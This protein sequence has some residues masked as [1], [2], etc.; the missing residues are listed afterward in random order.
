MR[1]V[2]AFL[3]LM[4]LSTLGYANASSEWPLYDDY[5]ARFVDANGRVADVTFGGK[6]TS[7]G[8]S[9]GLFF[10]LVANQ[11]QHFDAILKW[12]SDNL[13]EGQLGDKL[14]AWLWNKKKDGSWGVIDRNSASDSDLWIAY[15]LLQAERLWKEP[16]YGVMGRKLLRTIERKETVHAD[17]AGW[18]FMPAPQ[19]FKLSNNRYRIVSSYMPGFI[20]EYL[21]EVD[22]YGP[23]QSIWTNF[24]RMGPRIFTAG[25]AP[26]RFVVTSDDVVLPDT[27]QKPSASYDSIRVYLWAGMSGKTGKE[28]VKLL[29][30]YAKLIRQ[31][32]SP[33]ENVDPL[34][35][36]A[37]KTDYSPMGFTGAV[38]PYLHMV[39]DKSSLQKQVDRLQSIQNKSPHYYDQSLIMFGKGWLDGYYRFDEGGRLH[40]KWMK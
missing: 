38:L 37:T 21:A 25:I 4:M 23:W 13:A 31:Y 18:L 19:G 12:T 33:P 35:G 2:R 16:R 34:T 3:V 29:P 20:F 36:K 9:Y 5:H 14:P 30:R 7:E 39:G 6:T 28:M 26:D 22:P 15:S 10:A 1:T 24:M 11:R 27:E 17:R 40:T 8:Q 32:G